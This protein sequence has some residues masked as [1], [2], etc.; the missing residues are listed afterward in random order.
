MKKLLCRYRFVSWCLVMLSGLLA[1]AQTGGPGFA[2][3]LDGA[4][5]YAQATNGVWFNGNFTVE[6]WVYVR[7]YN[8]WSR[9]L[10][11]ANGQNTNNV[12]LALSG[13]TGGFPVFGVYTNNNGT[14]NFTANTQL[15]LNQWAHLAA[16]LNG[17]TGTIYIN[18]VNVG[19]G[20]L[21]LPPNVV[22]TNNYIG[23]SNYAVDGYA[24]ALFD[25]IRIWNVARTQGQIQ[26]YM[27]RSLVGTEAGL[28]GYWRV[29][30]GTG[31]ALNDS[32]GH[33]QTS[34]ILGGTSWTNST[35]PIA[36]GAGSAL[37]FDAAAS[38]LVSI[39]HQAALNA[40]PLTVMTWFK[41]PST[42]LSGAL[43][44]KYSS[45]SFNGYQIFMSGGHLQGWYIRDS[46]NNVY[47]GGPMDAGAV[48]D[49]LWH[50]A[51]MAIDAAGGR[52]Y[53]DGVL[54]SSLPWTGTAG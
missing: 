40:Y 51:A 47:N 24:N 5:G 43:V 28:S 37:N 46:G 1:R 4:S 11:F 20:A 52:L 39:P 8:N 35:A 48:N 14:P 36:A 44:N 27:H 31:S 25:E 42:N 26:G 7:S 16:T 21:N 49:G 50:H 32:S 30:E 6:A 13:G 22:R 29:D 15:P 12:F 19:S 18:G 23:R 3:N 33:G 10:D 17:T 9:L 45:G 34:A 38:Q 41:S 2:P 53:L 54:K